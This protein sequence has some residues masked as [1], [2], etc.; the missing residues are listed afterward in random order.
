MEAPDIKRELGVNNED[1]KVE[2]VLCLPGCM[3]LLHYTDTIYF[4]KRLV[5]FLLMKLSSHEQTEETAFNHM[6][7]AAQPGGQP[8]TARLSSSVRV[9]LRL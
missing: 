2:D 6:L 7:L 1:L 3:R 8:P 5:A 4:Q 9:E